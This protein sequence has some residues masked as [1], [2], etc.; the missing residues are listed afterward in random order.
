AHSYWRSTSGIESGRIALGS[1]ISAYDACGV[2]TRT[3]SPAGPRRCT[4][5][6]RTAR[7]ATGGASW[8][9]GHGHEPSGSTRTASPAGP[10][11]G[12]SW[13]HTPSTAS[14]RTLPSGHRAAGETTAGIGV[15]SAARSPYE[16]PSG[17]DG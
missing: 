7:D 3:V 14:Q 2:S 11:N 10:W 6:S 16:K 8:G 12:R 15:P 4:F 1:A 9:G 5:P 17:R 13:G